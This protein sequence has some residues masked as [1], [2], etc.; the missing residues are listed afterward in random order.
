V[1]VI[2][3][4]NI[5]ILLYFNYL[6]QE[7]YLHTTRQFTIWRAHGVHMM[8]QIV[9]LIGLQICLVTP[10][11]MVEKMKGLMRVHA[12]HGATAWAMASGLQRNGAEP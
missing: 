11:C 1:D 3:K 12:L 9:G 10:M 2:I 8:S 4:Q 7:M 5:N 6:L